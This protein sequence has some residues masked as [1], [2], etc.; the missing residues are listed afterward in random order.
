MMVIHFTATQTASLY[1]VHVSAAISIEL[2]SVESLWLP[3]NHGSFVPIHSYCQ[4]ICPAAGH[5]EYCLVL[6]LSPVLSLIMI[7]SN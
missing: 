6:K 7:A 3:G 4:I 2:A 5:R 1:S